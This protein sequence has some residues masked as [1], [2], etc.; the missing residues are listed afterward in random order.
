MGSS[1]YYSEVIKKIRN[2]QEME[3]PGNL[4]RKKPVRTG[5]EFDPNTYLEILSHLSL[6]GGYILDFAYAYQEGLGGHPCMYARPADDAP[7]DSITE[8][9]TWDQKHNVSDYLIADGTPESFFEL[10]V[11]REVANQFY[12]YWHAAYNDL[13]IITEAE[14]VEKIVTTLND[15]GP[16]KF[17]P[18]ETKSALEINPEPQIELTETSASV[19]YCTFT[20]WGGFTLQ[21]EI[22]SKVHPH[23]L[24]CSDVLKRV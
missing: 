24:L 18:A 17:E 10:V 9:H 4:L 2:V 11:F 22:F 5:A 19:I 13:R 8:Q 1:T 3:I 16:V 23:L 21:Q 15:M 20:Q 7:F 6:K 14:E 12:L